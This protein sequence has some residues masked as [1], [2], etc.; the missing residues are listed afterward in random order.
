M[1]PVNLTLIKYREDLIQLSDSDVAKPQCRD[2]TFAT[3]V[4]N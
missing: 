3:L 1:T 2:A 4:I